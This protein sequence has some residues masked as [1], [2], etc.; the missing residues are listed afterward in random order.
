MKTQ[1]DW[2]QILSECKTNIQNDIKPLL[3]TIREPQPNLGMGAGGDLMK[4]V[5]L[6]AEGAIV[7]TLKSHDVFSSPPLTLSMGPLT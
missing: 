4:P 7:E 1:I 5:D 3:K 2:Q 6:A